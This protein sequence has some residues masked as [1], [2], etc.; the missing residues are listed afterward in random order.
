[1]LMNKEFA[2]CNCRRI[3]WETRK[4]TIN[5]EYFSASV[6]AILFSELPK[7]AYHVTKSNWS[8]LCQAPVGPRWPLTSTETG[9]GSTRL[10]LLPLPFVY[11]HCACWNGF[12]AIRIGTHRFTALLL[13]KS[14]LWTQTSNCGHRI[15]KHYMAISAELFP[16]SEN[17]IIIN[18]WREF[19]S[20]RH[21]CSHSEP[22]FW[23]SW[24]RNMT[25]KGKSN[26]G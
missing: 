16:D 15:D 7:F 5:S 26:A 18:Q 24:Q 11:V 1:M 9:T 17:A 14:V 4:M 13:F 21:T 10:L 6:D 3:R 22:T 19:M 23:N 20:L 2:C 12:L 25:L 8:S